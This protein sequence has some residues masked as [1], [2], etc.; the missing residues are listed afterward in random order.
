MIN[1]RN[2]N[3]L[4]PQRGQ[5][6]LVYSRFSLQPCYLPLRNIRYHFSHFCEIINQ[7]KS[8]NENFNFYYSSL[9]MSIERTI[10]IWKK[11]FVVLKN[12]PTYS[13]ETQV[14]FVVSIMEM[15]NFIQ[16]YNR[17]ILILWIMMMILIL[18]Q[19]NIGRSI[20]I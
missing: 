15:H 16:K 9:H 10:G 17:V 4:H 5:Y 14:K 2:S 19:R 20:I 1:D 7:P 3:F 8:I 13:F 18:F 12:M 11:K 6:Y